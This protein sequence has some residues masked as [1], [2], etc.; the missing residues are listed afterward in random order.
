MKL[1]TLA[2][3]GLTLALGAGA[4]L[5]EE[6]FTGTVPVEGDVD[7][8]VS[9][10]TLSL[11]DAVDSALAAHPGYAV[12]AE[13]EVEDGF[14]VY[15]V[16]V[17]AD[18]GTMTEVIVDAG[19]GAVLLAETESE[20]AETEAEDDDGEAGDKE[21]DAGR[22]APEVTLAE[23]VRTALAEAPGYAVWAEL[24]PDEHADYDM[25]LV[26]AD[27]EDYGFRVDATTGEITGR[28]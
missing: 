25:D 14:L 2:M 3:L 11:P 4:A 24:D 17:I 15:D 12:E 26:D 27:G 28:D 7:D 22:S 5:A 6:S 21:H 16:E 20:G 19:N 10:A 23:A 8:A 18:D 1:R 9:L 13:L